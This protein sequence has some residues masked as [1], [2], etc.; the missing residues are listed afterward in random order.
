MISLTEKYLNTLSEDILTLN[1]ERRGLTSLPDLSRFK[2]LKE[3]YLCDNLL[4]SLPNNLPQGIEILFLSGNKL[5]SLPDLIR[6]TN[7]RELWVSVNKLSFMPTLP[8]S[9][10]RLW[11]SN[12]QITYFT[13]LS[14]NLIDLNCHKNELKSLPN[15]PQNLYSLYCFNNYLTSIPN[16]PEKMLYVCYCG[17]PICNILDITNNNLIELKKNIEIVNNFLDLYY[18]L[19]FKKQFIKWLWKS[20]EKKITEKYHPK[21]LLENL[22]ENT[23]LDEFLN[24]W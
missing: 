9:L 19:P 6:F 12:N 4:V 15:L 5:S 11:C 23:D 24:N 8:E 3:L 17:N 13:N 20:R 18:S 21:Y 7:L 22:E 16:L 10:E 2:N 1:L 14:P